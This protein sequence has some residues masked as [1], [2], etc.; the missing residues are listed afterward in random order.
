[1]HFLV[2]HRMQ[3]LATSLLL[4]CS[5]LTFTFWTCTFV[6][7]DLLRQDNNVVSAF[8]GFHILEILNHNK[9]R[10]LNLTTSSLSVRHEMFI[11]FLMPY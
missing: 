10:K 9:A 2:I 11:V 7:P 8:I 4:K 3:K 5:Y 6:S 1:M